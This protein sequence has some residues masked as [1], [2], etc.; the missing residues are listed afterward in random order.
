VIKVSLISLGCPKNLVDSEG[1]LKLL[2]E[3]GI[4]HDPD[5]ANADLLLI[6]T[7][8]FIETAK[9]ESIEEILKL[10]ET[11]GRR[12]LIVFGCLAKRYGDELKKEIPEIDVIFGVG[13]EDTIVAYCKEVAG[14]RDL[15]FRVGDRNTPVSSSKPSLLTAEPSS[16]GY[17]KIAEGC[18]R[19]CTY[20][21]IP[22]IR[23]K[24]RSGNP[25]NILKKAERL[26]A[27]GRKELIIIAQD[28]TSF[29]R[30][31]PG[32]GLGRLVKEIASIS[33]DFWV[34]LLYLYPTS[35]TD[36]LI[37]TVRSEDKVCKYLDIPLQHTESKILGLMKRGGGREYYRNLVTGLREAIPGVALRTTLITGFPQENEEDFEHMLGF[38]QEMQFEHLGVFPYSRE[39]GSAAYALK[40]Q[41][42]RHVREKRRDRI[43][44][45][46]SGISLDK[47][48][49]LVG[50]MFRAVVD[51]IDG[52]EGIARIYS[53]APEIDGVVFIK[54]PGVRKG[55]FVQVRI[56]RAYDYD[57]QGTVVL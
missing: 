5:P 54:G 23:G 46:Q 11:K 25:E 35:I 29:G 26:V 39:E 52:V 43:M 4:D 47:N 21:V 41:V 20:C 8:G 48:K 14:I 13:E 12:R 9:R 19:G 16:Y 40:G 22:D 50:K 28:I 56:D 53:Q 36:E 57:L 1:L 18:D 10:V 45:V 24:F 31:I 2:A 27:S 30:D 34:R 38:V 37:E 6:N 49:N 17:L 3:E 55:E 51:D 33:G 7:C 44:E 15:G 32:Y 42:P